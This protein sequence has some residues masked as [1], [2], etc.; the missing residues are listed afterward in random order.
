M[1]YF[2]NAEFCYKDGSGDEI[3]SFIDSSTNIRSRFRPI[4]KLY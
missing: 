1:L 3:Y 2:V 4:L